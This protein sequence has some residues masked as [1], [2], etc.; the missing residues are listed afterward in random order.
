VVADFGWVGEWLWE[1]PLFHV[2]VVY[3]FL[4]VAWEVRRGVR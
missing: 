4:I 2:V 1:G 3:F